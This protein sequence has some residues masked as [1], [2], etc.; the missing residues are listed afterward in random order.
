ML[1]EL[2]VNEN[3]YKE[4]LNSDTTGGRYL[5]KLVQRKEYVEG[6]LNNQ[7]GFSNLLDEISGSLTRNNV[8]N[9]GYVGRTARALRQS[10]F[11]NFIAFP[12]EI[13]RTGN[14][15]YSTAID[16]IT[17][18]IGKGTL[19]NPEIPGLMKLGLKRLFSFGM[20]VGGVPYTLVQTA[21]AVHN[22][23]DEEMEA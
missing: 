6:A 2:G 18:G 20:T 19:E 7:Q 4:I 3:N 11:G 10:P 23:S 21:K 15:I 14:N 17:S 13:M 9:Y 5:N 16:E 1:K 22:V 12:L 8:P